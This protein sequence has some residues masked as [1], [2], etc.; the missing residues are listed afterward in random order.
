MY[1]VYVLGGHKGV[2]ERQKENEEQPSGKTWQYLLTH[3]SLSLCMGV[4][5]T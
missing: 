3:L 4:T 2:E 1:G 5:H